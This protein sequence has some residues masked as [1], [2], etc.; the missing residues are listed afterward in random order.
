MN[1]YTNINYWI[2]VYPVINFLN[3]EINPYY[4]AYHILVP[5]F[6]VSLRYIILL[7]IHINI[8]SLTYILAISR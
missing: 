7:A 1:K 5:S 6:A 8:D 3:I 4:K 2:H